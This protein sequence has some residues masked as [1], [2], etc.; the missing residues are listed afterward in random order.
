MAWLFDHPLVIV[1]EG[2]IRMSH[3][4]VPCQKLGDGSEAVEWW[5]RLVCSFLGHHSACSRSGGGCMPPGA[6]LKGFRAGWEVVITGS[7]TTLRC[8]SGIR[9]SESHGASLG[10]FHGFVLT[11][12]G[13]C[14]STACVQST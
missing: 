4:E 8:H 6:T 13:P 5:K 7:G 9:R 12:S 1:H 3:H 10:K 2:C 14:Q 11:S